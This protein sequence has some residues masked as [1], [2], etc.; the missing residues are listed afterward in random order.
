MCWSQSSQQHLQLSYL[1]RLSNAVDEDMRI[2]H[3]VND[4]D[5]LIVTLH[6]GSE[7]VESGHGCLSST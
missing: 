4:D 2:H 6:S 5:L 3:T 1:T 7:G